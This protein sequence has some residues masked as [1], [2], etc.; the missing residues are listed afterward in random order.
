MSVN[1]AWKTKTMLGGCPHRDDQIPK[2]L[3]GGLFDFGDI[4]CGYFRPTAI[5]ASKY[6]FDFRYKEAAPGPPQGAK[7]DIVSPSNVHSY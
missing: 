4:G 3:S 1:T 5:V 7:I 2:R 6:S